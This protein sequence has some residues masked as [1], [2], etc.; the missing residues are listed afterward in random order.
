M[1][2]RVLAPFQVVHAGKVYRA[3][4]TADAP[5]E[6]ARK[7]LESGWVTKAPPKQPAKRGG[8]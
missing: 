4:E 6:V 1:I 2:V 5:D 7:W 8:K 3:G